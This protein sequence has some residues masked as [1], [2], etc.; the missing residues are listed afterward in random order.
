[1]ACWCD[2]KD[3]QLIAPEK[4]MQSFLYLVLPFPLWPLIYL[5]PSMWRPSHQ[6]TLQWPTMFIYLNTHFLMSLTQQSRINHKKGLCQICH[7]GS[8]SDIFFTPCADSVMQT[9]HFPLKSINRRNRWGVQCF[10]NITACLRLDVASWRASSSSTA[11]WL[12]YYFLSVVLFMHHCKP[13]TLLS[14]KLQFLR[15]AFVFH[16]MTL[17]CHPSC[18]FPLQNKLV[19]RHF[20]RSLI[21]LALLAGTT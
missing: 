16:Q 10:C 13:Q 3:W 11:C 15:S 21:L 9:G 14:T 5:L 19:I 12:C 20:S 8:C 4:G 18:I 1:M 2:A 17:P 7:I 6:K